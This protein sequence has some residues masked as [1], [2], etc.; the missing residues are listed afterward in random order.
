MA[1]DWNYGTGADGD[2]TISGDTDLGTV[3]IKH[4]DTLTVD[5][6]FALYAD[7]P[8]RIF[9]KTALVL[10]GTIRVTEI[11]EGG[12]GG[13]TIGGGGSGGAGGKGGGTLIVN[14]LA[15]TG[16]GYLEA[17][18]EI[19]T[20]GGNGT[21]STLNKI[22]IPG[23]GGQGGH[24][25]KPGGDGEK[26]G[27]VPNPYNT[28]EDGGAG[29]NNPCGGGGGAGAP[30][31]ALHARVEVGERAVQRTHEALQAEGIKRAA[32]LDPDELI[33]YLNILSDTTPQNQVEQEDLFGRDESFM[34]DAAALA[35]EA[36]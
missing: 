23:F 27:V 6:T 14:A 32:D 22:G 1:I 26:G 24:S 20:V 33:N 8:F 34:K 13:T 19:G 35:K 28:G 21:A 10:N 15:V 16:T 9:C 29:G 12:D 2:V 36:V 11:S 17:D 18:G 31:E 5:V 3:N 7:S 4:Y 25:T 30:G